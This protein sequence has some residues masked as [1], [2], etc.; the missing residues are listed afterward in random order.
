M[1]LPKPP[2]ELDAPGL[3]G[4]AIAGILLGMTIGTGLTVPFFGSSGEYVVRA[5][6]AASAAGLLLLVLLGVGA[7]RRSR[8]MLQ[9]GAAL[10]LAVVVGFVLAPPAPGAAVHSDGTGTAGTAQDPTAYWQGP[11]ECRWSHGD[12]TVREVVGFDVPLSIEGL[13]AELGLEPDEAG[14]RLVAAQL[15]VS[16]TGLAG[17]G[18]GTDKDHYGGRE[19]ALTILEVSRRGAAGKAASPSSRLVVT[20][21]CSTGP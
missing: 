17:V 16:L 1:R 18:V 6:L 13:V 15:P 2:V 21:S 10:A 5:I 4:G 20:W 14:Q 3:A 7:A 12:A 8:R 11:L 9:A 19:L